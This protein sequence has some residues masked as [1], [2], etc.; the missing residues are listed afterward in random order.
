MERTHLF[1]L[2]RDLRAALKDHHE[3]TTTTK[4]LIKTWNRDEAVIARAR[5]AMIELDKELADKDLIWTE[6]S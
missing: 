5:R 1:Y 2:I 4:S 6:V 3:R